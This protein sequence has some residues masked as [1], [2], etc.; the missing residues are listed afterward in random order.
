MSKL[1]YEFEDKKTVIT[2]GFLNEVVS[3]HNDHDESID[4]L[5]AT[6]AGK[7]QKLMAGKGIDISADN[8]ISSTAQGSVTDVQVD[9]ES[10]VDESGVASIDLSGKA[11]AD[12]IPTNVSELTNDSGYVTSDDLASK[13][14]KPSA[15]GTAGQVLTLDSGGV[16]YWDDAQVGILDVLVDEQSVVDTEGR[17]SITMPTAAT[18]TTTE[19]ISGSHTVQSDLTAIHDSISTIVTPTVI[20]VDPAECK[21]CFYGAE[22][23]SGGSAALAHYTIAFAVKQGDV[24]E[25]TA[26]DEYSTDVHFSTKENYDYNEPIVFSTYKPYC[27]MVYVGTTR[28]FAVDEDCYCHV[29]I[30]KDMSCCPSS[31][32]IHRD[33]VNMYERVYYY[34]EREQFRLDNTTVR[35]Y[36]ALNSFEGYHTINVGECTEAGYISV[37]LAYKCPSG[38]NSYKLINTY[39]SKITVGMQRASLGRN[40]SVDVPSQS[41]LEIF[42]DRDSITYQVIPGCNLFRSEILPKTLDLT[43]ATAF[44]KMTNTSNMFSGCSSLQTLTL[45]DLSASSNTSNMFYVCSSLQSLTLG[46]FSASN[47]TSNMFNGCSKLESLTCTGT[48]SANSLSFPQSSLLT[49]ESLKSLIEH[50]PT[51]TDEQI[52]DTS[53][54]VLTLHATAKARLTD[55]LIAAATNKGWQIA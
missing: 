46:D 35:G 52:A 7:Q 14:D 45:G 41:A 4:G 17:A 23:T 15:E 20:T 54:G 6:V 39:S 36:A 29:Y 3:K 38:R 47:N 50:L 26:N 28:R 8:V 49:V 11:D 2:A 21:I 51:L 22:P 48:T 31:I 44:P 53:Y 16:P 33:D 12:A 34:D 5:K 32:K 19:G 37:S 42:Y 55:D 27:Q 9:G 25:I 1:N 30:L 24:V 13:L 40:I 43:D 18:M 10:V